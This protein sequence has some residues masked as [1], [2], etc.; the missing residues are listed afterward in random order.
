[1]LALLWA[2]LA[3]II[4]QFQTIGYDDRLTRLE[5]RERAERENNPVRITE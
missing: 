3:A 5:R 2:L 4:S 1:L